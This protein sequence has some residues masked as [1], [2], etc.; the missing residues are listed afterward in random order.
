MESILALCTA[1]LDE[2]AT[3]A[4]SSDVGQPWEFHLAAKRLFER[5]TLKL[6]YATALTVAE[7]C[8]PSLRTRGQC[9]PP[10]SPRMDTGLAEAG[11]G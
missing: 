10:P 9:Y 5:S 6:I 11:W 8:D 2:F 3:A 4:R 7:V 1:V